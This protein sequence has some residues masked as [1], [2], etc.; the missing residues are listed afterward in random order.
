MGTANDLYSGASVQV[1]C[2]YTVLS[3]VRLHS[4]DGNMC[5]RRINVPYDYAG[6]MFEL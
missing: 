1:Q 6:N 3:T 5:I 2:Q 4:M